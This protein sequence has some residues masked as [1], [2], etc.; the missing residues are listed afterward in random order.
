MEKEDKKIV[1]FI[2]LCGEHE[3]YAITTIGLHGADVNL[4]CQ[5]GGCLNHAEVMGVVN[6]EVL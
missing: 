1:V 4:L 5:V 6:A 2:N 3:H